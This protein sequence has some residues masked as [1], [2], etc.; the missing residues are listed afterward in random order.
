MAGDEEGEKNK[1]ES[2]GIVARYG[3]SIRFCGGHKNE[4]TKGYKAHKKGAC[5]RR[6]WELW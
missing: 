1:I 2:G 6:L 3:G 5:G 4:F